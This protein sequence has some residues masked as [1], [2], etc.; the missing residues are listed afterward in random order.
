M[1]LRKIKRILNKE[2]IS[3]QSNV[4]LLNKNSF[5]LNSLAKIYIEINSKSELL[6]VLKVLKK[7]I[8]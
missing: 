8:K 4:S 2:N 5:R 6:K 7:Y 1:N 3:Y